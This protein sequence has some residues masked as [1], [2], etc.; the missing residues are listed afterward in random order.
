METW[1]LWSNDGGSQGLAFARGR[2]ESA[3]V[4]LVHAPPA[5][6]RVAVYDAAGRRLAFADGLARAGE[7]LPMCRL[8]RTG[9][10]I[11]RDEDW[12]GAA[13]IGRPVI[14]PGGE[15][16]ILRAWW[17]APDHTEWRWSVEF[18]NRQD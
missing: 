7:R 10:R 2:M 12:P 18:Y 1:D 11:E 4:V 3:T 9:D 17:Q 13:D 16:G 5:T 6:L 14:L 15:V 8:T